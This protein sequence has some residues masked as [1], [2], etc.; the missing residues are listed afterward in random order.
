[1]TWP[2]EYATTTKAVAIHH[3]AD[4]N[5]YTC[6]QSAAIVRAIYRF[7]SITNGW[8][9]IGY[10]VLVDKCGTVF[11]GRTGGLNLPTIGAHTGGF[12]RFVFGISM[13]GSYGDVAPPAATLDSVNRW[14]AWKLS[15][16]YVDST[17]S[18]ILISSGGG[19][20]KYPAGTAVTLP[21]I[22]AHRDVGNTECPGDQGYASLGTIRDS[23]VQ[24]AGDWRSS[25]IYQKWQAIGGANAAGPVFRLESDAAAGGRVTQFESSV[26][27][28]RA[29]V[30][31]HWVNGAI[32]NRYGALGGMAGRLGYPTTDPR[33]VP[34][35]LRSTFEHGSIFWNSTT[36]QTTAYIAVPVGGFGATTP[37]PGR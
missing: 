19:T 32:Y 3:T 5:D 25:P 24:L 26:I 4:S 17:A 11:E 34:G 36:G 16:S 13:I 1:M 20:S 12:N 37:T 9:D 35:G 7:H 6:A 2:P 18:V 8:G 30:G 28:W 33:A 23:V 14:A 15:N 29:D 21:T 31:A 22:F 27:T 10:N